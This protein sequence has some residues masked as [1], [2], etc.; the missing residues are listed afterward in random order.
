VSKDEGG[1][2]RLEG[3]PLDL[4]KES[5]GMVLEGS[6]PRVSRQT[7]E[8]PKSGLPNFRS[9]QGNRDLKRSEYA[10][11][12]TTGVTE[13]EAGGGWN[14]L[15]CERRDVLEGRLDKFEIGIVDDFQNMSDKLALFGKVVQFY[16]G[17]R[18]ISDCVTARSAGINSEK[19]L[20]AATVR[21]TASVVRMSSVRNFLPIFRQL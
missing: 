10:G 15:P 17:Q 7:G 19:T 11:T 3:E 8:P 18:V 6:F 20:H 12:K 1:I 5:I 2:R 16:A 14:V 4:W 21:S 9:D 13:L